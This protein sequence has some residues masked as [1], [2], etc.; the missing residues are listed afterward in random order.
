MNLP[1]VADIKSDNFLVVPP[2]LTTERIEDL[3]IRS[4]M[5]YYKPLT[6]PTLAP[7]PIVTIQSQP[8]PDFGLAPS[9]ENLHLKLIDYGQAIVVDSPVVPGQTF[10]PHVFRAPEVIMSSSWSPAMDIWSV[11]CLLFEFITGGHLFAP[12]R[13]PLSPSVHLQRMDELLG[14][15]PCSFLARC[16]ES[17]HKDGKL[18]YARAFVPR[19]LEDLLPKTKSADDSAAQFIRRS[20]TLDPE[21]RPSA[22]ELLEDDWLK[23]I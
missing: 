10:Q 22:A 8:L 3:L 14:P 11:G 6:I 12:D 16:S 15:F 20:L 9:L 23:A 21:V 18:L 19:H 7:H 1:F 13:R 4:S 2:H 17:F 5:K